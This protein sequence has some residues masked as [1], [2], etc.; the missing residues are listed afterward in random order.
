MTAA[1]EL[2]GLEPVIADLERLRK[3][4]FVN[5]VLMAGAVYLQR[6]VATYP[7]KKRPTRASVYGRTFKTVRQRK[8][9]FA[10]L[11]DGKIDVPYRRGIS[12]G[13]QTLGKRWTVASQSPFVVVLGNNATYARLVQSLQDQSLYMRAVG[14]VPVETIIE[15]EEANVLRYMGREMNRQVKSLEAK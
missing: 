6:K 11:A 14:W 5:A 13:S 8:F 3:L 1:I 12:P 15:R 2:R 4:Q 10:A 9:F 7:P